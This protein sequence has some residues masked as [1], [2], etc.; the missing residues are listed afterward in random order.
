VAG[1]VANRSRSAFDV[2]LVAIALDQ[3]HRSH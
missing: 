1:G 2:Q 3:Q